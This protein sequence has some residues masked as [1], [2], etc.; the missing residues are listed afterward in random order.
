MTPVSAHRICDIDIRTRGAWIAEINPGGITPKWVDVIGHLA[1]EIERPV[2]RAEVVTVTRP[3]GRPKGKRNPIRCA[4]ERA[5]WRARQDRERDQRAAWKAERERIKAEM[6]TPEQ[7]KI[8][9]K[10]E[11]RKAEKVSK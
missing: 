5:W 3:V 7:Q 11:A 6:R 10:Y 4:Q 1:C 8:H 2:H 9:D